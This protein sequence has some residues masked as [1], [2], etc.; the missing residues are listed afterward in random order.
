VRQPEMSSAA[1]L[2]SVGMAVYG[3]GEDEHLTVRVGVPIPGGRGLRQCLQRVIGRGLVFRGPLE[4]Y[5]D[6][7][8]LQ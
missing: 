5:N 6:S 8:V 2:L 4:I 1:H 7:Q 3:I